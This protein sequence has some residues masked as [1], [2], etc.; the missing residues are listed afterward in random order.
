MMALFGIWFWQ[1]RKWCIGD[2]MRILTTEGGQR[3]AAAHFRLSFVR[4]DFEMKLRFG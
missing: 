4:D 2:Q 1:P 3:A